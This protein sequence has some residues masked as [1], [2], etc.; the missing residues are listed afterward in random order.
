MIYETRIIERKVLVYRTEADSEEQADLRLQCG[1]LR[2]ISSYYIDS[3]E[4]QPWE[5][6]P[7]ATTLKP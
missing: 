2:P 1:D 3:E 4:G 5:R 7:C 6:V